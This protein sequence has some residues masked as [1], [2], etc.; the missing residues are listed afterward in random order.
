[1]SDPTPVNS[2]QNPMLARLC[3]EFAVFREHRPLALGIHKVL[4]ER[5]PDLDK[6]QVR[7]AMQQHTVTTRY[8]KAIIADAPRFDL[9]GN[10]SGVVTREQQTQAAETLRERFR[11]AAERRKAELEAQQHQEKLQQLANK[12]NPR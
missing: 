5:I 9:D 8:L 1:M 12:F 6:K 7:F 4:L 2:R 11:K 3:K 10:P